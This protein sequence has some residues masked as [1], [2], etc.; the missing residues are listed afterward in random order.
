MR[1][2]SV[3]HPL[4]FTTIFSLM[5]MSCLYAK[6][7][8]CSLRSIILNEPRFS[9]SNNVLGIVETLQLNEKVQ[10]FY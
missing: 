3:G 9:L 1:S 6:S 2:R 5:P 8:R 7:S 4:M 10:Q